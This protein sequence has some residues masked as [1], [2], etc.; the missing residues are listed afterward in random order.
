M[1]LRKLNFSHFSFVFCIYSPILFVYRCFARSWR[2]CI[3]LIVSNIC[4]GKTLQTFLFNFFFVDF[5]WMREGICNICSVSQTK[6]PSGENFRCLSFL[7]HG[8]FW[9]FWR[10]SKIYNF[11]LKMLKMLFWRRKKQKY[12]LDHLRLSWQWKL[13]VESSCYGYGYCY[14]YSHC[15]GHC[16]HDLTLK[17][18]FIVNPLTWL[19]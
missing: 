4:F 11:P 5:F 10:E 9:M 1:L 16:C 18:I 12:W 14:C 19:I 17:R 2:G 8:K 3:L 7:F 15:F 13:F 6:S